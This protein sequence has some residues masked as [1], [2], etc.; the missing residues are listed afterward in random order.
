MNNKFKKRFDQLVYSFDMRDDKRGV[1]TEKDIKNWLKAIKD[2]KRLFEDMIEESEAHKFWIEDVLDACPDGTEDV[3]GYINTI[4][5]KVEELE[6][7]NKTLRERYLEFEH[8]PLTR[9]LE[10]PLTRSF[11]D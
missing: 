10:L 11:G 7:E 5:K 1:Y 3:I 8:K 4:E 2:H 9:S 6:R